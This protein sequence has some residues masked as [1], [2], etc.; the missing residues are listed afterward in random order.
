MNI[1][2][3]KT[4]EF[5]EKEY[6]ESFFKKRKQKTFEWY[7]SYGDLCSILHKYIKKMDIVLV[8]GCGNSKLSADMYQVGIENVTNIDISEVVIKNMSK[9]YS[10]VAPKMKWLKMDATKMEFDNE[11]FQ[12]LLDKGTVDAL[13]TDDSS[14][15]IEIVDK[16]FKEVERVLK[17]GGRFICVS[18]LQEHILKKILT[19]F[20]DRSW[21]VRV[22]R[23]PDDA[24]AVKETSGINFPVF[25]IVCTKLK[26]FPGGN[27]LFLETALTSENPKK[28]SV[29]EIVQSVRDLQL[30]AFVQNK[31]STSS[32]SGEEVGL[33]LYGEGSEF[34]R[35]T[36]H[37]VDSQLKRPNKFAIFIVPNGRETEWLFGS[38]KGRQKLGEMTECQRLVVAHLSRNHSYENLEVIKDELSKKVMTLQPKDYDS[39]MMV[40]FLSVGDDVGKRNVL[41][42]CKSELNGEF[43]VED[44]EGD[45]QQMYRRLIFLNSSNTIQSD[46]KLTNKRNK[47]R[48]N[49]P[50]NLVVDV[51]YLACQHLYLMVAGY[52][53]LPSIVLTKG[54]VRTLLIGLGGGSLPMF[55]RQTISNGHVHVVELDP[56]IVKVATDYFGFKTDERLTVEVAD[57]LEYINKCQADCY[58]VLMLDVDNKDSSI[59]MSFPPNEFIQIE[60]LTTYKNV[61]SDGGVFVLNLVCRDEQLKSEVISRTKSIF[62]HCITRGVPG[63]VNEIVYAINGDLDLPAV[64]DNLKI[65]NNIIKSN[66]RNSVTISEMNDILESFGDINVNQSTSKRRGTR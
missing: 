2:P 40:Q 45:E 34:P 48:K 51:T 19:W 24:D 55:V 18:L 5:R 4:Q 52:A 6:W 41:H 27:N 11:T 65:L 21:F 64:E 9:T 7:G 13:M 61:L 60:T 30:M 3:S 53:F 56:C 47:R 1:L 59:G 31:L 26:P 10:K 29:E 16:M 38:L 35:Y 58:N 66:I 32:V 20:L 44:V 57:G 62:K 12:V 23:R 8:I 49:A 39:S 50:D 42:R 46:A 43:V 28:C 15:V 22:C 25:V 37:V 63:Q 14:E 33:H 54:P 36:L 17:F